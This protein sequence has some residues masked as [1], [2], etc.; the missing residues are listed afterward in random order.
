MRLCGFVSGLVVA[1]LALTLLHSDGV[2]QTPVTLRIAVPPTEGAAQVFYAKDMGFFA[3]A[4][5]DVDVQPAQGGGAISAA[6]VSNSLDV[7]YN[8]VDTLAYLHQ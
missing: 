8:S 7:G 2:A 1:G 5:L 3:Q 4:G 6:I